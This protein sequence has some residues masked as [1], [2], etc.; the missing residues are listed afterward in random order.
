MRKRKKRSTRI[1]PITSEQI[2]VNIKRRKRLAPETEPQHTFYVVDDHIAAR[3]ARFLINELEMAEI[4][5]WWGN[6]VLIKDVI[7]EVALLKVTKVIRTAN[8][9][10]KTLQ[11]NKATGFEWLA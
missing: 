6:T 11:R 9:L 3:I 4:A 1:Q 7:S 8:S 2:E 10:Y 5:S